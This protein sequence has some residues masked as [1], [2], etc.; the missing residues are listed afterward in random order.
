MNTLL[1]EDDFCNIEAACGDVQCLLQ[2]RVKRLGPSY[3]YKLAGSNQF[4]TDVAFTD[5]L[6]I[7]ESK[8]SVRLPY[9]SGVRRDGVGD[10]L[11][12][13]GIRLDRHLRNPI[14]LFEHG[15]THP[16]PIGLT[17]VWDD[18]AER[19]D[20]NQYTVEI[21]Q[22]GQTAYATIFFYR[23]K[24]LAGLGDSPVLLSADRKDEYDHGVFCEQLFHWLATGLVRGGS[25]GYMILQAKSLE[26]DYATGIPAGL[27]LLSVLQLECS[28]VVTPASMDTVRKCL[29]MPTVCGKPT[30]PI[31]IKSLSAYAPEETKTVVGFADIAQKNM[32]PASC[33]ACGSNAVPKGSKCSNCGKPWSWAEKALISVDELKQ[34]GEK[35]LN[36]IRKV[37][38]ELKAD[39]RAMPGYG[40]IFINSHTSELWYVG[41]D[42]D[43]QAF[44]DIVKEKLG[45]VGNTRKEVTYTSE[46]FPPPD[47]AW[48]QVYPNEKS[49]PHRKSQIAGDLNWLK[50][51]AAEHQGKDLPAGTT[52]EAV[53][54]KD[55]P[56][57]KIP[58]SK[59]IP[60]AGAEL[61]ALRVKYGKK[62]VTDDSGHEHGSDG[63]FTGS[64]GG[65]N[66]RSH[67]K[68]PVS[69]VP[70]AGPKLVADENV[71]ARY[72]DYFKP[73]EAQRESAKPKPKRQP[74]V[75]EHDPEAATIH[76]QIAAR[77]IAA[78]AVARELPKGSDE[79]F[80]ATIAASEAYDRELEESGI[81]TTDAGVHFR[82]K[83]KTPPATQ[84]KSLD[85]KSLRDRYRGVKGTVRRLKKS[86]P[87]AS[88]LHVS[89]KDLP[90]VRADA[91]AAGLGFAHAGTHPSGAVRVRLT[92]DDAACDG[93]AKRWGK[94]VKS[95]EGQ[96]KGYPPIAVPATVERA[97][98]VA[99][100]FL[101]RYLSERD[102]DLRRRAWNV[103]RA[104][105]MDLED[106][107]PDSNGAAWL[108]QHL[109]TMGAKQM[110]KTLEINPVYVE[111]IRQLRRYLRTGIDRHRQDAY[112]KLSAAGVNLSGF[113]SEPNEVETLIRRL[114]QLG[115]KQIKGAKKMPTKTKALNVKTKDLPPTADLDGDGTTTPQEVEVYSAQLMRRL[116]EDASLL[117]QQY[118]ELKQPLEHEPTMKLLEEKLEDLV[119]W[120]DRY[121]GHFTEHHPDLD[122]LPSGKD[123][124]QDDAEDA[125]SDD[126]LAEE[127]TEADSELQEL[128]TP[129]E[130][131]E[132][133]DGP[134][135]PDEQFKALVAQQNKALRKHYGKKGVSAVKVK[136]LPKCKCGGKCATCK[137]AKKA[138]TQ[139]EAA[140]VQ[141]N[142]DAVQDELGEQQADVEIKA[143]EPH[144]VE[145]VGSAAG[146]LNDLSTTHELT[147]EHRMDAH[148]Y[149]K[150]L[151]DIKDPFDGI[152]TNDVAAGSKG[153][154]DD[155]MPDEGMGDEKA[156]PPGEEE[157][158]PRPGR[159][160]TDAALP[161]EPGYEERSPKPGEPDPNGTL[162]DHK[163]KMM[164]CHKAIKAAKHY[165]KDVSG[166]HDGW[167]ETHRSEALIHGKAMEAVAAMHAPPEEEMPMDGAADQEVP[168]VIEPGAMGEKNMTAKKGAGKTP[169]PGKVGT[170]ALD[171]DAQRRR[172]EEEHRRHQEQLSALSLKLDRLMSVVR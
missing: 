144:H 40:Q 90:A 75:Y 114:E 16:V 22:A 82:K 56:K 115:V 85:L 167:G 32:A 127:D 53:P 146:F 27:H 84:T 112:D 58:P 20:S 24:G 26:P 137:S 126:E 86:A 73:T 37:G 113:N 81:F 96:A 125:M 118:H 98:D 83:K 172:T 158:Q 57:T 9:A 106:V 156:L 77:N 70:V 151:D 104:A 30:S 88:M 14:S 4:G 119:G 6:G 66:R 47:E 133:S 131:E 23:G 134:G 123:L 71:G 19:Y 60:G 102:E 1:A 52:V 11:E 164:G 15:K 99:S 12:V 153:L 87:G 92:G 110:K 168:P 122:G 111:A 39:A 162:T 95:I 38:D 152:P 79:R 150:T 116:H 35:I 45:A 101:R 103:L 140:Q 17:A 3:S 139:D 97:Y 148:H 31:L 72:G 7:D 29:A 80:D 63:K 43:E 143:L 13:G 10:L 54:L 55:V 34:S 157:D 120:L 166:V 28:V 129:S 5:D 67:A 48:K 154:D 100:Q 2:A 78:L 149:H 8:M 117:L 109:R 68:P 105:G 159:P 89:S 50:E 155:M 141:G 147:N 44:E 42:G 59:W 41:G 170:K 142:L 94:R 93:I 169:A 18:V 65:G 69:H 64:G 49:L 36:A 62:N 165:L 136:S 161:G 160:M 163:N 124:A 21:D 128:D 108:L 130:T 145:K 25:I 138:L 46:K 121:E 135:I 171:R 61:K 74:K 76:E 33:P 91:K 51:E 107:A 132:G